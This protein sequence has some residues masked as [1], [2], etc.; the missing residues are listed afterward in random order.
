MRMLRSVFVDC[1]HALA[2]LGLG[3]GGIAWEINRKDVSD[4]AADLF[5]WY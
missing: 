2:Q 4:V 5:A 1:A 3:I